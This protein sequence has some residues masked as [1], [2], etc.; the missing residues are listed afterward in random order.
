M[1][2]IWP[3]AM[4]N[5]LGQGYTTK[6]G[7]RRELDDVSPM[8]PSNIIHPANPHQPND[9]RLSA[10][11][12]QMSLPYEVES[13]VEMDD[14]LDFICAKLIESVKAREFGMG[15]RVWD[16]ALSIWMTMGYPMKRDVK[17]K[18]IF[19]Y[20]ETIFAPGLSASFIEDVANQFIALASDRTLTIYDFRIPWRPLYEILYLEL[21]PHPNKLARHSMNLAPS[22]L[23]VAEEAQRFFHPSDVDDMLETILPQLQP[24]MDSILATQTFLVHFLPISHCQKWL[25]VIFR[26]WQGYNSGLWDDQASDLMGQLAIAHVDPARSDPSLLS[27]IP[28]GLQNTPEEELANPSAKK[29]ARHHQLRLLEVAGKVQEDADGLSYWVDESDPSLPPEEKLGSPDWQGIRKDVGIF[30]DEQFEFLMSK[31][32]RSLNVPVGGAVASQNSMS[33][34]VADTR[35]SK[36]ILDAKKPIDRVQSLAET[37]VFSIS[38]DALPLVSGGTGTATG[39]VTPSGI[40]TPSG[41]GAVGKMKDSLAAVGRKEELHR[42]YLAGSKALDHLSKL[43]TSCETVS[44]SHFPSRVR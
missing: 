14:K 28:R 32:L 12:L 10:V 21:F 4:P 7:V 8:R 2:E 39:A 25:P 40:A 31:C 24:N 29:R 11:G 19:L 20:Y 43:L 33:V 30:T 22:L 36:K 18:L 41:K 9:P 3:S 13:L 37:I 42:R 38:E 15:F 34:T 6:D 27:K 17:I 1:S 26:F 44:I 35:A 23:N 16:S 5:R